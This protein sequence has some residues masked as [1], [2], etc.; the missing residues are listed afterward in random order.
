MQIEINHD[1][2][3]GLGVCES[4]APDVFVVEDDGLLSVL[5][6]H[7]PTELRDEMDEAARS[8]PTQ[9]ITVTG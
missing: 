1:R 6:P 8:C 9:A 2:C 5:Q 3:T 7:P 4:M